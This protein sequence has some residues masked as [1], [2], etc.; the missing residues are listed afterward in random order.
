MTHLSSK[1]LM[2]IN[3]RIYPACLEMEIRNQ[4]STAYRHMQKI[5]TIFKILGCF[6]REVQSLTKVLCFNFQL[7]SSEAFLLAIVKWLNDCSPLT[8]EGLAGRGWLYE[9]I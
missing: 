9:F 3:Y 8:N 1:S 2:T 4:L 6:F 7:E 5:I